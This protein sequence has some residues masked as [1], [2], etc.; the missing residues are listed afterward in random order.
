MTDIAIAGAS[1]AARQ[2]TSSYVA[3]V[4]ALAVGDAVDYLGNLSTVALTVQAVALEKL[5]ES[6]DLRY[7]AVI[8]EAEKVITRATA[9]V[10][11]VGTV[12][13]GLAAEFG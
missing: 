6:K 4:A 13:G 5:V 12:A 10:A 2:I 1:D 8:E 9:F 11:E 7:V 3:E